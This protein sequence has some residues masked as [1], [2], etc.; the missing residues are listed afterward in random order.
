MAK[1]GKS[2]KVP[3]QMQP[4]FDVIVSLTDEFCNEYLN[5]EYAQLVRQAAAALC[6][7]RPSPLVRGRP[8]VWACAI[9]Y[10]VGSVNFLFDRS[11]EPHV[12]PADVCQ[13]FGVV[14]ST[15]S[16][17]SKSVRDL[18]NMKW[19]DPYWCLPSRLD[20][21]PTAWMVMVD[22]LI[23][24]ARHMPREVQVE[25]AEA[26]FIPHVPGERETV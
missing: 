24:D 23:M 13:G 3:R 18:L 10:A 12:S 1:T 21:H 25:L 16:S 7:K 4:T 2:E 22:G 15:G 19:T 6:R 20:R 8:D 11:Q 5:E 9:V 14:Q 26:G 17:K